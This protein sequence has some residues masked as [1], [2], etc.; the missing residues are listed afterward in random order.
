[1]SRVVE[2]SDRAIFLTLAIKSWL[3][4]VGAGI[5]RLEY[6]VWRRRLEEDHVFCLGGQEVDEQ[7]VPQF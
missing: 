6:G 2:W 5:F 1:M 3:A 7:I 4:K